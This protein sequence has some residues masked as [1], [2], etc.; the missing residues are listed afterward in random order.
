MTTSTQDSQSAA[1]QD[2]PTD[3][4]ESWLDPMPISLRASNLAWAFCKMLGMNVNRAIWRANDLQGKPELELVE[5]TG[6]LGVIDKYNSGFDLW[7]QN[8][9]I[10]NKLKNEEEL[11]NSLRQ[12][13]ETDGE[14]WIDSLRLNYSYDFSG[15]SNDCY[16][17]YLGTGEIYLKRNDNR[18]EL[19]SI[20]Q[21]QKYV[22]NSKYSNE[23]DTKKGKMPRESEDFVRLLLSDKLGF[24]DNYCIDNPG[25]PVSHLVMQLFP[26]LQDAVVPEGNAR[27]LAEASAQSDASLV[28]QAPPALW[29]FDRQKDESPPEFIMR[30]YAPWM[31]QGL[32]MA[33]IRRLDDPLVQAYYRHNRN[34]LPIP[35]GFSMARGEVGP[36]HRKTDNP[37]Q[38]AARSYWRAKQAERRSAAKSAA[39]D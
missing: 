28:P 25:I 6:G 15:I 12:L 22:R 20:F 21:L 37:E 2:K 19:V 31:S 33:D 5:K 29:T 23:V 24:I 8:F 10:R 39:K 36:R 13:C 38:A 3:R 4:G 26:E 17:Q 34:G 32:T 9:R 7:I 1:V 14:I 16:I 27:K 35:E 30:V 18:L 11:N